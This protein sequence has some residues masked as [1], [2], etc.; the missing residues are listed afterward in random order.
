MSRLPDLLL[1]GLVPAVVHLEFSAEHRRLCVRLVDV[2]DAR[3]ALVGDKLT[4]G[5]EVTSLIHTS[6][7]MSRHTT[8]TSMHISMQLLSKA[9]KND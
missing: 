6:M 3:L 4:V 8:H 5:V 1:L 9:A 7:H 2:V